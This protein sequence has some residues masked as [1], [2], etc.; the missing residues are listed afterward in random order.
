VY[1]SLPQIGVNDAVDAET[2]VGAVMLDGGVEVED[3]VVEKPPDVTEA[4]DW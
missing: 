2:V 1:P 3:K 4:S